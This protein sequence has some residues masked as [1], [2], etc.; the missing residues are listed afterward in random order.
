M[1]CE[2]YDVLMDALKQQA[3]QDAVFCTYQNN[4]SDVL[5]ALMAFGTVTT[6]M[7]IRTRSVL[8]PTVVTV[9]VGGSALT[10]VAAPGVSIFTA[11]LLLIVGMAPVIV[12][13]RLAGP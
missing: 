9:L 13:R 7:Y 12:I 11:V 8:L 1:A 6:A 5:F 4:M 10:G 2:D 3:I